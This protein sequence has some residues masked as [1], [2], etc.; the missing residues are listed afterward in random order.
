MAR[1]LP[2]LTLSP[3]QSRLLDRLVKSRESAHSLVQRAQ[4]VVL[5][6]AGERN[7]AISQRLGLCEETVGL[8]RRRWVEAS[9]ELSQWESKPKVLAAAIGKLKPEIQNILQ[10]YYGQ[11]L[12][13]QQIAQELEM[14]QNA[15][16]RRLSKAKQSLLK[17]LAVWSQQ[18]LGVDLDSEVLKHMNRV[19]HEWLQGYFQGS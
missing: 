12:T 8:W 17:D 15:V 19:I 16:S 5:A 14:R 11:G 1:P 2:P 10:F 9:E 6:A 4:L 3:E 13:Q 7:K 18:K